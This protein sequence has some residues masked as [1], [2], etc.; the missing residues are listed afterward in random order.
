MPNYDFSCTSCGTS[1]TENVR[2][3]E[4]DAPRHCGD[5][6]GSLTR[7]FPAPAVMSA[8]IPDHIGRKS[9]SEYQAMKDVARL[10]REA[11]GLHHGKRDEVMKE[12]KKLRRVVK[13]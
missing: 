10:Q 3:E 4:R 5:C 7:Q 8:A 1:L 9:D 12:I 13:K 2:Y 6:G 11:A